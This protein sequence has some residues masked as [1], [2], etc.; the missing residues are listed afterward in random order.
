MSTVDRDKAVRF[1]PHPKCDLEI[2]FDKFACIE[3]WMDLPK[4]LHTSIYKAFSS[5]R[6]NPRGELINLRAQQSLAEQHWNKNL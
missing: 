5:F 1:C 6:K 4:E 2:P 3:H